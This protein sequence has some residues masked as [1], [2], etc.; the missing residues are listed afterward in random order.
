[1]PMNTSTPLLRIVD[2]LNTVK[3]TRIQATVKLMGI[4]LMNVEQ[5]FTKAIHGL[6]YKLLRASIR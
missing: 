3:L 1:M 6:I 4:D 5:K 2:K